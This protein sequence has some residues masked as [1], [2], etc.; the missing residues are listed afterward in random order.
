MIANGKVELKCNT[1][2]KAVHCKPHH[3]ERAVSLCRSQCMWAADY[4]LYD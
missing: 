3:T 4:P 2:D 1:I